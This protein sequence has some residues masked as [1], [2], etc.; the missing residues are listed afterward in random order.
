MEMKNIQ[1]KK[2]NNTPYQPIWKKLAYKELLS[3]DNN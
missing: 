3:F 1:M 2:D